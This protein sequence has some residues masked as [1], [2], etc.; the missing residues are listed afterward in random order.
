VFI[1][2]IL[3]VFCFDALLQ[4]FILKLVSEMRF[5]GRDSRVAGGECEATARVRRG[6]SAMFT[7]YPST[8]RACSWQVRV[9]NSGWSTRGQLVGGTVE[10]QV[11][12][13]L[14]A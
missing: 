4:V 10:V 12:N 11:V 2:K 13:V 1:L 6:W 3:K 9:N 8:L 14:E 5:F 7:A